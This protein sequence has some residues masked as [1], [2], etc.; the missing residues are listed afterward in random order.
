MIRNKATGISEGYGFVEF[1]SHATADFMLRTCNGAQIPNTDH[2]FR[3]NWASFSNGQRRGEEQA[4]EHSIF[5]GDLAADVSDYI[6]QETFRVKYPSVRSAKCVTDP[7]SGRS[8]GY[9]FVRFGSEDEMKRAM[10]EMNGQLLSNRPMRINPATPKKPSPSSSAYYV[11]AGNLQLAAAGA[12]APSVGHSGLSVSPNAIGGAMSM[13]PPHQ[14]HPYHSRTAAIK[15]GTLPQAA[16][17]A[18]TTTLF[19]GGLDPQITV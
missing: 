6:L 5:V 19:V 9:G 18:N 10:T 16:T 14:R 7:A 4:N 13:V 17:D 12:M 11:A 8:K 2:F 1:A 15:P 3:L